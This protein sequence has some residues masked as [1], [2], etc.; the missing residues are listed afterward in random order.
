MTFGTDAAGAAYADERVFAELHATANA[1]LFAA[2]SVYLGAGVV[3]GPLMSIDDLSRDTADVA[4]RLLNG[5]PPQEHQ[6]GAAA[7]RSTDIRLARAAA[8][9]HP[10]EPVAARQRRALSR[11]EPVAAN[12]GSRC[13]SAVGA[14]AVQSLLIVGLLYQRRA[15]QRAEIDSRRNL[16]LAAD[17]SR[18]QTMS[19]LT[20]SIAHELGQPL[21]SIIHNAQA[22][23]MM[24]TANRAT[25]DTIGEI[26]S[27]IQTQGVQA[28]QIIDRHR[29]MLRSHQLDMKPIDLHAVIN[30]SL[31]LVAHDMRARQIEATVNLSRVR[32]SSA[33]IRCSC[34]RCS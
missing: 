11:S 3:G 18:R 26:L 24:V 34:S 6:R 25:S 2:H 30:D 17:A 15:R 27:D 13:S 1:P 33:A 20:S 28:T 19:A 5:A 9:G 7:P 14:L 4:I 12:T 22:L 10:R 23:Q 31:A 8:M 16:A 21:S 29:T 32:A